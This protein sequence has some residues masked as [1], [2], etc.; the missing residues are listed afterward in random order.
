MSIEIIAGNFAQF[1]SFACGYG[2]FWPTI[3]GPA[4]CFHLNKHQ[5]LPFFGNQ[6]DL[7]VAAAIVLLQYTISAPH[8]SLGRQPFACAAQPLPCGLFL[9]LMLSNRACT[10]L[11]QS[12]HVIFTLLP[13][14]VL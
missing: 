3:R 4:A 13:H 14:S 5:V 9:V 8:Q 12:L 10:L 11:Y 1:L 2:L 6:I 7:T